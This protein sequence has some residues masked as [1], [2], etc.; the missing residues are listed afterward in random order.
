MLV[1]RE[2]IETGDGP[3]EIRRV[4]RYRV[5]GDRFTECW[6]YEEDQATGFSEGDLRGA[7]V[8]K[9]LAQ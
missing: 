9:P 6:L 3:V 7:F 8:V 2:E 4:L 5:A 1:A